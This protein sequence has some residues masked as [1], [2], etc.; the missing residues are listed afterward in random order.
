MVGKQQMNV[1]CH[2]CWGLSFGEEERH[3]C[4]FGE[5][6]CCGSHCVKLGKHPESKSQAIINGMS[7]SLNAGQTDSV[8]ANSHCLIKARYRKM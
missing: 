1:R 6:R 7:D 8:R 2:T 3:T 4:S 5:V